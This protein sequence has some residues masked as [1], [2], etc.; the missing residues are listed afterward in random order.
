MSILVSGFFQDGWGSMSWYDRFGQYYYHYT[1][2]ENSWEHQVLGCGLNPSM[3][4]P[5]ILPSKHSVQIW[6]CWHSDN[7][8][9]HCHVTNHALNIAWGED[10]VAILTLWMTVENWWFLCDSVIS[11]YFRIYKNSS[12]NQERTNTQCKIN[13]ILP[14]LLLFCGWDCW[15]NFYYYLTSI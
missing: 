5:N 15:V 11:L 4:F 9:H 6:L 8:P 13:L 1:S 14:T 12:E 2:L 7:R 10:V 3:K